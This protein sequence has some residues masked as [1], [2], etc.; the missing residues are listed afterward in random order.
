MRFE[1]ITNII[2]EGKAEHDKYYTAPDVAKFCISKV[3]LNEYDR[4]IEPSAGNGSFSKLI[5]NAE[6]Y[7]LI[8]EDPSVK[9]QDFLKFNTDKGNILVIGNPPFGKNSNLAIQFIN[10]AAKFARTIAFILPATFMRENLLKKLDSHVVLSRAY[11]L[12]KNSFLINGRPYDVNCRYFIFNVIKGERKNFE[13]Q[14]T[15]DFKISSADFGDKNEISILRKGYH[16]GRVL[17][18][19]SNIKPSSRFYISSNIDSNILSKRLDMMYNN[20]YESS[21]YTMGAPCITI[22]DVI[23]KYNKIYKNQ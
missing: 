6:A 7:D 21:E 8:P 17:A 3:N 11:E 10:N 15:D 12:P 20:G 19:D 23:R 9:K 13:N 1:D 2:D 14:K 5:P 16:P 22:Q 4:I 18:K